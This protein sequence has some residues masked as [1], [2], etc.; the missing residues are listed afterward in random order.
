MAGR[1][2]LSAVVDAV[3]AGLD[4]EA[5]SRLTA[6]LAAVDAA[7]DE[8]HDPSARE[9]LEC[10]KRLVVVAQHNHATAGARRH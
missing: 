1:K 6:H 2:D 8:T 5:A 7:L 4:H 10:L 9:L 3:F